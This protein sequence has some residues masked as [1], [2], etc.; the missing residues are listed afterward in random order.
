MRSSRSTHAE[1]ELA[2]TLVA[3]V[4]QGITKAPPV[5]DASPS[6]VAVAAVS[7]V[8]SQG[9]TA[10]CAAFHARG[11]YNTEPHLRAI[12]KKTACSAHGCTGS[13][14]TEA[15]CRG[16]IHQ[17]ADVAGSGTVRILNFGLASAVAVKTVDSELKQWDGQDKNSSMECTLT[18]YAHDLRAAGH[19]LFLQL[20]L[21][22]SAF[23]LSGDRMPYTRV[24]VVYLE[25][26]DTSFSKWLSELMPRAVCF[27]ECKLTCG[28]MFSVAARMIA[29]YR[30][31]Y[32][33]HGVVNN[34]G[35]Y[36]NVLVTED[37]E[38][39]MYSFED[40]SGERVTV[41]SA[42]L[43]VAVCDFGM[44]TCASLQSRETR[45]QLL[46]KLEDNSGG[47]RS[48]NMLEQVATNLNVIV[49]ATNQHVLVW[50]NVAEPVRDTLTVLT[51][52]NDTIRRRSAAMDPKCVA[53]MIRAIAAS[54]KGISAAI[55][56][57]G[58]DLGRAAAATV[59]AA[60]AGAGCEC[61]VP[62][63]SVEAVGAPSAV[64][65]TCVTWVDVKTL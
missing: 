50:G 47:G 33:K 36:R 35:Y 3:S 64:D 21:V 52:L 54:I 2:I 5:C 41:K 22:D 15:L 20:Y 10:M 25:A 14:F 28:V 26:A 40:T 62:T 63:V 4:V 6:P 51:Q 8:W 59:Y 44:A 57:G 53:S 27:K 12:P 19:P 56:T 48:G 65:H 42:G 29:A 49:K 55:A 9:P 18:A 45:L 11:M 39:P 13:S 32:V 38:G 7:E 17:T 60:L 58:D 24:P 46:G 61:C 43:R 1:L 30:S 31:M 37:D 34:D 16:C 23:T